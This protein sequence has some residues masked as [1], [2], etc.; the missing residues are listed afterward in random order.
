VG[1]AAGR[2]GRVAENI[3][4]AVGAGEC[5]C[6]VQ[7]RCQRETSVAPEFRRKGLEPL[8]EVASA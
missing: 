5:G 1:L 8:D 3:E 7:G 6:V 2:F 4:I